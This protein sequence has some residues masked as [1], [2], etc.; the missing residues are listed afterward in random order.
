MDAETIGR[1][2]LFLSASRARSHDEIDFAV[3]LSQIRKIGERVTPN[4]PLML[5]HARSD[6][7]LATALPLLEK[8]LRIEQAT[9]NV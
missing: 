6:R 1:A 7:H 8:A 9:L 3:G 5:V 4:E 2:A